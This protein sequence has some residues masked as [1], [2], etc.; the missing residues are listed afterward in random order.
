MGEREGGGYWEGGGCCKGEREAGGG[1]GG[2]EHEGLGVLT[3]Y[4]PAS[5][6]SA[7]CLAS[8]N[9]KIR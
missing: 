9:K 7:E 8:P 3:L 5:S 6:S 2:G 4:D 1:D